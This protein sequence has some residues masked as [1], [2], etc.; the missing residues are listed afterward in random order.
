MGTLGSGQFLSLPK[1]ESP[2][3]FAKE[4][5]YV[6][7]VADLPHPQGYGL[8]YHIEQGKPITIYHG[9]FTAGVFDQGICVKEQNNGDLIISEGKFRKLEV[10]Y[11]LTHGIF[12]TKYKDKAEDQR[13]VNSQEI[14]H[15]DCFRSYFNKK[16]NSSV[17]DQTNQFLNRST[18]RVRTFNQSL[19]KNGEEFQENLFSMTQTPPLLCSNKYIY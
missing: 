13:Y 12:I 9:M 4:F 6:G 7:E 10:S 1:L 8:A 18:K 16:A 19:S 11:M 5:I 14:S 15:K 17:S 2:Y 3:N